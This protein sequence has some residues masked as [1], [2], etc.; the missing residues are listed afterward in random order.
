[1]RILG[2]KPA[3]RLLPVP[4]ELKFAIGGEKVKNKMICNIG[5]PLAALKLRLV[6][7]NTTNQPTPNYACGTDPRRT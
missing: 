3:S 6:I 7:L 2:P 5:L 1:M 4:E